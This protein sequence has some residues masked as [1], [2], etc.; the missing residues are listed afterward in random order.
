MAMREA[1]LFDT[2][3][4]MA[5]GIKTNLFSDPF[6]QAFSCD[7]CT[8]DTMQT[9]SSVILSISYIPILTG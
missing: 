2:S 5:F 6:E 7:P 4:A 1:N 8:Y 9:F 3:T